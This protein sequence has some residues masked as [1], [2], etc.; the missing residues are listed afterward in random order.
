[1]GEH[2][3]KEVLI[4]LISNVPFIM[5]TTAVLLGGVIGLAERKK[6]TMITS[7]IKFMMLLSVGVTGFWAFIWHSLF[8]AT[9]ASYI[10]WAPS[11]F[12]FEVA[13]AYLGFGFAGLI[14]FKQ[15]FNY[16]FGVSVIWTTFSWGAAVG[17]LY[18]MI[19]HMNFAAGNI[20]MILCMD[21]ICP[22]LLNILLVYYWRHYKKV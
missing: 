17:N 4:S 12:Q 22:L 21:V 11:P 15:S 18:Q 10:G 16:W 20:G 3:F 19:I 6:E 1:M 2:M 9:V 14:G 13:V 5:T 7:M 8:G